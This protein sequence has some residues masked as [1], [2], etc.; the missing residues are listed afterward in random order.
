MNR[1]GA[2]GISPLKALSERQVI[3]TLVIAAGLL[4]IAGY[5]VAGNVGWAVVITVLPLAIAAFLLTISQYKRLFY[6]LFASHFMVL[7]VGSYTDVMIGAVTLFINIC[8]MI[9]LL[10]TGAYRNTT[11]KG[12]WNGMTGL[13]CIWGVYCVA[14]LANPNAVQYAWNV[15]MGHYFVYPVLCA[16]LVPLAIRRYRNVEWLLLLWSFFILAAAFKGY[17][18]K[19]HGFNE[20]ELA[21]LFEYGAAKTHIIWSGIR[22]FSFFTDAANFGVHMAMAAFTFVI[23]LFYMRKK[24]M[25]VYFAVVVLAAIYGMFISGTRAAIAVPLGGLVYFTF[26][27]R[28]WKAFFI[29]VLGVLFILLL[30]RYT[31]VGESNEYMRKMRSAFV[32]RTDASYIARLENRERIKEYMRDMPFGYGLGLGGKG[33]RY[34]A[35]KGIP[36]PPDSWLVNVWTDTGTAGFILYISVHAL[37]FGWCSRILMFKI[38]NKRLRLVLAVWLCA[39]AGFFV[40][41]YAND[42][43]QYPNVVVVYTGFALCIA[44]PRI[45]RNELSNNNE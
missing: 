19:S 28:R 36:V 9:L 42:V 24:W 16:M 32:P 5:A 7:F 38:T 43:M 35:E 33:E 41:A 1:R 26:M 10:L 31:S 45:E 29:G 20:R 25:R 37:L 12:S 13:F 15:A 34:E 17:W 6:V 22:Y 8:A 14:E 4:L 30:F 23:S 18:Q 40:S 44:A 21:F 27:S 11:W 39:N 3:S 2:S